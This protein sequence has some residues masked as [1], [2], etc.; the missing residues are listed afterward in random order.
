MHFEFCKLNLRQLLPKVVVMR[1]CMQKKK[2]KCLHECTGDIMESVRRRQ[3][4]QSFFFFSLCVYSKSQVGEEARLHLPIWLHS[5]HG[6]GKEKK[7]K[8]HATTLQAN[9]QALGRNAT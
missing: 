6:G 4:R 9:K 7:N 8:T 3:A 5:M 2:T 1:D